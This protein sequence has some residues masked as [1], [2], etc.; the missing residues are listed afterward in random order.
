MAK[1]G[2]NH[3]REGDT[4]GGDHLAVNSGD[5][6]RTVNKQLSSSTT[7]A[8]VSTKTMLVSSK[9]REW[10]ASKEKNFQVKGWVF[11]LTLF[12]STTST[13]VASFP[14]SGP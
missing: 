1:T 3:G 11:L 9:G 12:P 6:L 10:R 13:T 2:G 14:V 5:L 8:K 7:N 4:A